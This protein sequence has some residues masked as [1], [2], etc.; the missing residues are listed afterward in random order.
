ML[1]HILKNQMVRQLLGAGAGM[2]IALALYSAYRTTSTAVRA[3]LV[4]PGADRTAFTGTFRVSDPAVMES[5]DR[6]A[7]IAARARANATQ[8]RENQQQI[9]ASEQTQEADAERAEVMAEPV[10]E[11]EPMPAAQEPGE[12]VTEAA[13][14]AQ[15]NRNDRL[16]QRQIMDSTTHAASSAESDAEHAAA[17]VLPSSG[18]GLWVAGFMA[19]TITLCGTRKGRM[20]LAPQQKRVH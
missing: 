11:P 16:T 12:R 1:K 17:P 3:Y 5:G 13:R 2:F 9:L 8:L 6:I 14:N 10:T 4:P 7:R 19:L 18:I 15:E 20:L